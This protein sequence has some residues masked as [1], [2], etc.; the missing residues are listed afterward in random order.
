MIIDTVHD[1]IQNGTPAPPP[2]KQVY[3]SL[4]QCLIC[5]STK[6]STTGILTKEVEG[7]DNIMPIYHIQWDTKTNVSTLQMDNELLHY[8]YYNFGPMVHFCTEYKHDI[9]TF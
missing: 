4:N 8:L 3:T 1:C 6:G 9:Y 7:V 5:K 2:K